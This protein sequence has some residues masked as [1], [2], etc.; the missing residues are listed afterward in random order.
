M[1]RPVAVAIVGALL[2]GACRLDLAVDVA[3][4]PDGT[5]VVTVTAVA[6]TELVA[7]VDGLA[8]ALV[9]DDALAAGW[10]I[11][12]P[13]A[14]PDGGLDVT[15][16]HPVSGHQELAAVLASIGPPFTDMRAA[17]TTADGQTTNAIDGTLVLPNGY[18]SFA[19]ADLLA[20]VGGL[21][22]GDEFAAVGVAPPDAM[23]VTFT[24]SLPGELVEATGNEVEQDVFAWEAPLDGSS[25]RAFAQT[26][27]R[28]ATGGSWAEPLATGALIAL[29]AWVAFA[30]GVIIV[31]VLARQARARRRPRRAG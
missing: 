2:L 17:R 7:R 19:D 15:L 24:V 14:T 30:A 12:G 5:G 22:F 18:E 28:P 4:E 10:D 6:D 23:S 21:P 26:V 25:V 31:V 11:T 1:L 27:Q 8:D 13:E 3:I 29:V 9:F 16:A 20:A